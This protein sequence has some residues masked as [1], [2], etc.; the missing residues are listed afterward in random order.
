MVALHFFTT[1]DVVRQR[2][3]RR[4]P[5]IGVRGSSKSV[6]PLHR[7]VA[8]HAEQSTETTHLKSLKIQNFALVSSQTVAFGRGLNV[9]SGESGAGKSVLLQA[10]N[11]VMGMPVGKDMIRG[12]EDLSGL[13]P[14]QAKPVETALIQRTLICL[15]ACMHR[16]NRYIV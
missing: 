15:F 16:G 4:R 12:A 10:L 13:L 1:A 2:I 3:V 5:C 14:L 9:I 7:C 6:L 8:S 11:V